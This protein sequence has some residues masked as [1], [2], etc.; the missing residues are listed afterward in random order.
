M[1]TGRYSTRHEPSEFGWTNECA[2]K[3]W[4]SRPGKS[5]RWCAPRDSS[6]RKAELTMARGHVEHEGQLQGGDPLG[7]ERPAAIV[8]GDSRQALLQPTEI[9]DGV[10][11]RDS[12]AVDTRALLHDL[13]HLFT[14][15]GQTL[16]VT[17]APVQ[18]L[19]LEP[20][21]LF[22]SLHHDDRSRVMLLAGG[23][24]SGGSARAGAKDQQL[25]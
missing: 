9:V 18:E 20:V 12:R 14:Q 25:G 7:V 1:V 19:I 13:L 15:Q 22:R 17:G 8:E 4:S 23:V 5:V 2:R 21:L 11:E 24:L 6:R 16:A 3:R 10:G